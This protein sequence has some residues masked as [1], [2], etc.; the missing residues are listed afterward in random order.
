M[1]S[2]TEIEKYFLAEKQLGLASLI[3]AAV[4]IL[5][6]VVF[7]F[8][9]KN[10]FYRGVA[11]PLILT[12]VLSAAAG[13]SVYKKSDADRV[14]N[15]YAYD[16][17][18]SA[19]KENELPRIKNVIKGFTIYRYTEIFLSLVGIILFFYFRNNETKL[20]WKGLGLSL[21]VMSLLVFS[22]DTTAQ[23]WAKTYKEGLES[24]LNKK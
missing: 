3:L 15:V 14:K 6:A 23:A 7:F 10:N 22:I 9:L 12:G 2:K 21:A 20:F 13:Y 24:F 11:I 17:N 18:P 19:L 5:V 8:F 1:F 4:L 16:M